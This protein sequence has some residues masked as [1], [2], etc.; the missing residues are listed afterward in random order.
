MVVPLSFLAA[1]MLSASAADAEVEASAARAAVYR[2]LM[3]SG[4]RV[5][6]MPPAC[7]CLAVQRLDGAGRQTAHDPPAEAMP[8][9][10]AGGPRLE[11]Y[12]RC[13]EA[14]VVLYTSDVSWVDDSIAHVR[15]GLLTIHS[16]H[17][18][19]I[20]PRPDVRTFTVEEQP[21]GWVVVDWRMEET[22]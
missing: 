2:I 22:P 9:A 19:R 21:D 13:R 4:F 18:L 7:Y 1:A 14:C 20:R 8:A 5:N 10:M 15:G 16:K 17:R 6:R 3:K 11:P 12:S